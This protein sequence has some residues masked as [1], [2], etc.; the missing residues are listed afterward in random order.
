[1]T[2][3]LSDARKVTLT[4]EQQALLLRIV[5]A[6]EPRVTWQSFPLLSSPDRRKREGA[7]A[8]ALDRKGLVSWQRAAKGSRVTGTATLTLEGYWLGDALRCEDRR[9]RN[10]LNHG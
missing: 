3:E 2:F 6:A 10:E 8:S 9:R 7:T 5:Q 4:L 1:M